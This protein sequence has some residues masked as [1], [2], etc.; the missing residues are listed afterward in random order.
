MNTYRVTYVVDGETESEWYDAPNERIALMAFGAEMVGII[1]M[2][3]I[4][5][6]EDV[7]VVIETG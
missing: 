2:P 3:G 7:R 6:I 5:Q 1:G 4:N